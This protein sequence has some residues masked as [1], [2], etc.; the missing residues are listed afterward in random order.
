MATSTSPGMSPDRLPRRHPGDR[1][2][3]GVDH[4]D[5]AGEVAEDEVA[6]QRPADGVLPPAGADDRD[7]L[8]REEAL[9]RGV[10]RAVLALLHHADRG[11]GRVDPEHQLHHAVLE[12]ALHLVA[13]VLEGVDHRLV[14][15]Q[16]LGDELVDPPLAARLGE[17]LEQELADAAALVGVLDEEGDLGVAGP[18]HVVAPD[19][20]HVPGHEQD[21]RDPVAVVDL[22]EPVEVA[23]GELGHRREEPVVLRLVRDAAVELDQQLAV[24]RLDRP[25]VGRAP[26]AQQD[27]GLPVPGRP[28]RTHLVCSSVRFGHGCNLSAPARTVGPRPACPASRSAPRPSLAGRV[29]ER[30]TSEAYRDPCPQMQPPTCRPPPPGSTLDPMTAYVYMLRVLRRLVRTS[31]APVTSP[32]VCTSTRSASGLSTPARHADLSSSSGTRST[33]TS[34]WRYSREKQVQR[35]ETARSVSPLIDA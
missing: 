22:G 16:H 9:D 6:H 28:R 10:L 35:L 29:A 3:A 33:R 21:H 4:V 30:G 32:S 26:V 13:G 20:D 17:V 23:L 7:R 34:A 24:L 18:D 2:G 1:V 12:R 27:V 15:G 31:A 25:D 5:S 14:V 8:R 11:V 19:G